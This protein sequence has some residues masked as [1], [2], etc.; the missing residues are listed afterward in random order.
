MNCIKFLLFPKRLNNFRGKKLRWE[1][2]KSFE[3]QNEKGCLISLRYREYFYINRELK[4]GVN[5]IKFLHKS[6]LCT[7]GLLKLNYSIKGLN[8]EI[9]SLLVNLS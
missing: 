1:R 4:E 3:N 8:I 5:F 2:L 9:C 6:F 7:P